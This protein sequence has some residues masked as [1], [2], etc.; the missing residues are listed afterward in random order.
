VKAENHRLSAIHSEPDSFTSYMK[1]VD[2]K[3][4]R[5]LFDGKVNAVTCVGDGRVRVGGMVSQVDNFNRILDRV[6]LYLA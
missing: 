1:F 2:L 4:A 5:Q 3:L 6:S